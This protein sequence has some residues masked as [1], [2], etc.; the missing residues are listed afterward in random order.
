[1]NAYK[2]AQEF[3]EEGELE[4]V[5]ALCAEIGVVH[6]EKDCF[7]CAYPTFSYYIKTKSKYANEIKSKIKLDKPDTWFVYITAGNLERAFQVIKPKKFV[8]FER[9]DGQLRIYDFERMRRLYG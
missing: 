6:S 3:Y 1:V 5:M 7:F 2:I 4:K 8:A 9:F